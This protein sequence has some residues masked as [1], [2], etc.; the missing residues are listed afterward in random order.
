MTRNF[1]GRGYRGWCFLGSLGLS[2]CRRVFVDHF[3]VC[4]VAVF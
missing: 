2:E 1:G 3:I 4:V